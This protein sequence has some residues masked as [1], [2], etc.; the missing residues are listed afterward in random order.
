MNRGKAIENW[1]TCFAIPLAL[2]LCLG[3]LCVPK[4]RAQ[5]S[6]NTTAN[7]PIVIVNFVTT[8]A[9]PLNP[10]FNG[11][12]NNLKNAVEYYDPNFQHILTTLSPGWLRFPGGT[13]SEAFDWASGEIVP[14][15][16]D[17][18]AAKPIPARYQCSGSTNRRGQ[19]RFVVQ[20]LRGHGRQRRWRENNCQRQ[21]LHGH[22]AI[23]PSLRPI[24]ADEPYPGSSVGTGQ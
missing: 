20:R 23:R 19:G 4:A 17:A 16:V 7:S 9:T 14:A 22:P 18:L 3:T 21:R 2:V 8:A 24:C 1:S 5:V 12:N 13:D 6:P 15:W 10:G 11:F